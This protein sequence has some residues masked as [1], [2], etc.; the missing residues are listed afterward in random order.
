MSSE[1]ARYYYASPDN[2]PMGPHT[3]EELKQLHLNGVITPRT[4][5]AKDGDDAWTPYEDIVG[6]FSPR[7]APRMPEKPSTVT[8]VSIL[9][10]VSAGMNFIFA[11]FYLFFGGLFIGCFGLGLV[12]WIFALACLLW[13]VFDLLGGIFLTSRNAS[14]MPWSFF[15]GIA[16]MEIACLIDCNFISFTIGIVNIVLLVKPEVRAYL[17]PE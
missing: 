2:K 11:F 16:I 10:F 14:G 6:S 1:Q 15:M 12:G 8:A 9:M 13:G 4:L 5:I 7:S 3:L 17:G